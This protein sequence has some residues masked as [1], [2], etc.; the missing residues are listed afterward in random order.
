MPRA[1]SSAG[2]S[3]STTPAAA[4][5]RT[6]RCSAA[7][8]GRALPLRGEFRRLLRRVDAVL[9]DDDAAG[10]E[11]AVVAHLRAGEDGG[12]GLQIRA[13]AVVEVV[14]LGVG[15]RQDLL[16]AVLPLHGE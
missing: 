8:P 4:A 7:S 11:L 3:G 9:A 14:V 5:S 15:V 13:G 6:A 10:G 1:S 16:L 12:A 2:S